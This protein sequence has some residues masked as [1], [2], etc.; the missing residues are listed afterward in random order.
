MTGITDRPPFARGFGSWIKLALVLSQRLLCFQGSLEG[1]CDLLLVGA[2]D[3]DPLCRTSR[4]KYKI[5]RETIA[6]C[7]TQVKLGR[8]AGEWA[9]NDEVMFDRIR[10]GSGA[11]PPNRQLPH[12]G[13]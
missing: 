11:Y 4:S 3:D 8:R 2:C 9:P 5:S 7:A 12:S 1:W 13:R 10:Q 6:I